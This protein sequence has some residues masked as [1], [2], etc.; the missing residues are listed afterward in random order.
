MGFC[1]TCLPAGQ[2]AVVTY[3]EAKRQAQALANET[4][5]DYGVEASPYSEGGH[6]FFRLPQARH[7]Q[8]YELRCEVVSCE[9]LARCAPGHGPEAKP[10]G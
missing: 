7:R 4:G 10:C 5:N 2:V 9:V 1:K 3:N 6:R 8:G